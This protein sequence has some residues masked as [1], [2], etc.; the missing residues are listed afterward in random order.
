MKLSQAATEV[1]LYKSCSKKFRKFHSKTYVLES[2]FNKAAGWW[3]ATLS[4]Q[5]FSCE[6]CEIFKNTFLKKHFLVKLFLKNWKENHSEMSQDYNWDKKS[7][8]HLLFQSYQLQH[9][10]NVQN[11]F[12][13]SNKDIRTTSM[14]SF[15]C[16]IV[17][18]KQFSDIILVFQSMT[19]NK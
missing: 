9:W 1:V 3:P 16:L 5:V 13:V 10:D 12:K 14:T 11:L 17:S 6:I 2:L 4:T 8:R 15:W 7:S 18:F 19:L